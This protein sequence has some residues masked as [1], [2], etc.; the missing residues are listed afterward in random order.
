MHWNISSV[1]KHRV[2]METFLSG[3]HREVDV[4]AL[5]ES[6]ME[7]TDGPLNLAG[8]T[9]THCFT[10]ERKPG[11]MSLLVKE[12]IKFHQTSEYNLNFQKCE[13][14]WITLEQPLGNS[15]DIIIGAIYRHPKQSEDRKFIEELNTT[16]SRIILDG[17]KC[18]IVGDM[19]I[20]L[21]SPSQISKDLT[22]VLKSNAMKS[23]I[24]QPTRCQLKSQ[25]LIDHIYT[26]IGNHTIN[27]FV[28][29]EKISDHYPV[30]AE[31][32]ATKARGPRSEP[33][34]VQRFLDINNDEF[35]AEAAALFN[36]AHLPELSRK[37][38]NHSFDTFIA[39][40]RSLQQ[41]YSKVKVT[42]RRKR[43]LGK[44]PW[45]T[46]AILKSIRTKNKLYQDMIR[47]CKGK[48]K[49]DYCDSLKKHYKSFIYILRRVLRRAEDN[50][51]RERINSAKN[52]PKATWNAIHS[53]TNKQK[54][55][56]NL[57]TD[58]KDKA[59]KTITTH[60]EIAQILN[61]HFCSVGK[62][63]TSTLP[64]SKPPKKSTP[65]TLKSMYMEPTSNHEVETIIASLDKR[66]SS[67]H[68]NIPIILLH[69]LGPTLSPTITHFFNFAID[70]GLYP[71]H[72]K[73]AQVT[74]VYKSGDKTDMNNYRPISVASCI[75]TVFEK[76]LKSRISDFLES[77]KFFSS[78][79]F[80]FRPD[81][82]TSQA[83]LH[84]THQYF[85]ALENKKIGC[86]IFM[87]LRKA[88][89]TIDHKILLTKLYDAGLR[90][91]VQDLLKDYLTGR[92]QRVNIDGTSSS[93]L[94]LDTGVPQGSSIS[95]LLFIIYINEIFKITD[96]ELTLFADDTHLFVEA[97]DMTTLQIKT[98]E[99]INKISSWMAEHKI[100][101]NPKKTQVILINHQKCAEK[102]IKITIGKTDLEID[103]H[104]KYLGIH[105]DNRLSWNLHVE[106]LCK[107][108]QKAIG[109]MV[110]LQTILSN[111]ALRSIYFAIFHQ[112]L[113]YGIV[114]W[115]FTTNKNLKR[116]DTLQ[117]KAI[118]LISRAKLS[119]NLDPIYKSLGVMKTSDIR[120]FEVAKFIYR[121]K[122][123]HTS[124]VFSP[125]FQTTEQVHTHGTRQ[126][127]QQKYH[128]TRPKLQ[129]TRK[130]IN[131]TGT[132]T[133]NSI[134]QKIRNL[135]YS[136]FKKQF[137][138]HTLKN[139]TECAC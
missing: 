104:A 78:C 23:L 8:Y 53:I 27:S 26:N 83:I 121:L 109:V 73:I 10:K 96:S 97:E 2:Q 95:P 115:G 28:V 138:A 24:T 136:S 67:G 118:R 31:M 36:P 69:A 130:G 51:Y 25:T 116:I 4:I 29:Q 32:V 122:A 40:I 64:N 12:N 91:K 87:D 58:I 30:V 114:A 80:G 56:Q 110:R 20:D 14:V 127:T 85:K 89:D 131:Y 38:F 137:I 3:L 34:K 39:K 11:G 71:N 33:K 126:S 75:G 46:P 129:T 132:A 65:S 99:E 108:L 66:K 86:S 1:K 112:H 35:Y 90:G 81:F 63:L 98:Q 125:L 124:S 107:K 18:F 48:Q 72:L 61:S 74:P 37:N 84:V 106:K 50:H 6:R 123:G 22:D 79:Q 43:K 68:D 42:S 21:K 44:R 17:K 60:S 76:L 49:S 19:N 117:R 133:W 52:D 7:T 103:D 119:A 105:L 13:Q 93:T 139:Y 134:P 120:N 59:G 57:L 92:L 47:T 102:Q 100:S 77:T 82:D 62:N 101:L 16:I 45:I 111:S 54:R 70:T 41:N 9:E 55:S 94:S 128:I 113:Q 88:F 5:S 135:P 15:Y